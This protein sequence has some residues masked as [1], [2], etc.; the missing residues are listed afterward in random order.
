[1]ASLGFGLMTLGALGTSAL[2]GFDLDGTAPK[3]IALLAGLGTLALY[4]LGHVA[5]ARG[6]V[7]IAEDERVD[8]I[9]DGVEPQA[10]IHLLENRAAELLRKIEA[11]ERRRDETL[12]E[13]IRAMPDD[14]PPRPKSNPRLVVVPKPD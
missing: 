6:R 8:T 10:R 2:I 12:V 13:F 1:M 4:H 7:D 14:K 11:L 5:L 9:A 3:L